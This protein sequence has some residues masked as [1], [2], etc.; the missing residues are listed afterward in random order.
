RPPH[1]VECFDISHLFGRS[2]VASMVCFLGGEPNKGHYRRFK[3]RT[4]AGIDD[5]ASIAEAVSRRYKRLKEEGAPMPDLVL[6]DGGKGQLSA[7]QAALES[8]KVRLPLAALAKREEEV[9]LPETR[10]P[11]RLDRGSPALRLLQRL[12]DEAHRFA[13]TYHRSLRHKKLLG[14]T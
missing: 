8:V 14:E 7:A 13:V 11:L 12:R 6:I 2:P 1:H 10:E 5:F 9:F 4:V 3:I